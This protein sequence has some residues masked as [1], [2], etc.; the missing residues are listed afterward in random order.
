MKKNDKKATLPICTNELNYHIY[1]HIH[2]SWDPL[3]EVG[4]MRKLASGGKYEYKELFEKKW[5]EEE[6]KIGKNHSR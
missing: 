6:E 2:V 4:L 3:F 5:R 1:E